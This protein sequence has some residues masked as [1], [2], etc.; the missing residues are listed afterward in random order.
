MNEKRVYERAVKKSISMPGMLFDKGTD[1]ARSYGYS[2]FS[3]YV[4]MLI[5]K[6][7]IE[8]QKMAA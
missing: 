7:T 4:Q 8:N 3:D 1:K 2:T 5:R 6:D